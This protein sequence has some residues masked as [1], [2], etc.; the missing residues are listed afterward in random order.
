MQRPREN[1]S[2]CGALAASCAALLLAATPLVAQQVTGAGVP[3]EASAGV[4]VM[5]LP[6]SADYVALLLAA[7]QSAAGPTATVARPADA[8]AP[9]SGPRV[10]PEIRGV[11]P[12]I[13]EDPATAWAPPPRSNTI[14]ISTLALVLIAVI[15]TILVVD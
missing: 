3:A 9:L 6:G 1:R 11:E 15:I 10:R 8:S 12:R 13:A 2:F 14:V 4:H 5:S 7:V